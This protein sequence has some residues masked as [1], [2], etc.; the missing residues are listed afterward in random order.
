M[1]LASRVD[2]VTLAEAT[3]LHLFLSIVLLMLLLRFFGVAPE[4][5]D[6]ALFS[7]VSMPAT[8]ALAYYHARAYRMGRFVIKKKPEP[9]RMWTYET[10][11]LLM[12]FV[13]G[14]IV[15]AALSGSTDLITFASAF[16]T[17]QIM[18]ILIVYITGHL[19]TMGVDIQHPA[20]VMLVSLS[21]AAVALIGLN[22]FFSIFLL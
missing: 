4:M 5:F 13:M 14:Y 10:V 22:I 8:Y 2:D 3:Q 1:S 6:V 17:V 18:R 11:A 9:I 7:C 15:F 19:R 20:I 16:V 12:S 21:I